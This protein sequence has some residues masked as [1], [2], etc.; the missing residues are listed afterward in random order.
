ME[1]TNAGEGHCYS[2]FVA[3]LDD[4]VVAYRASGLSYILNAALVC[5]LNVVAEREECVAAQSH[6]GVLG[7]PFLLLL[8]GQHFGFLLEEPLP[9]SFGQ[10]VVVLVADI[11]V[12]GVVAVSAA[13]AVNE[14]QVHHFR[15]LAQ[16]PYV[17]LVA[18]QTCAV[19]AALLSGTD[20]YGLSVLHVAYRVALSVL[21]R[22]KTYY[23]VALSLFGE[24]LV[25]C[26]YILKE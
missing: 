23:K 21:Q 1:Q 22:D 26:G 2:V 20:A 7:Y 8:H 14:R 17:G 4:I 18:C 9:C 16:P 10:H 12:D 6:L 19:Y 25:L 11:H 13:Y 15:M 5:T 3:G 24:C